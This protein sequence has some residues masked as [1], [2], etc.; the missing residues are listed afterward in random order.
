MLTPFLTDESGW[1]TKFKARWKRANVG[2]AQL[3]LVEPQTMMN[4]SGES[5]QS[6]AS[7]FRIAAEEILIVH[8]E[9]ELPFG[10][11]LVRRGG[12]LAGHNGLKSIAARLGTRE[13]LRLRIGIGRPQHGALHG[14]VLGRFTQEEEAELDWVFRQATKLVTDG[15]ARG[16]PV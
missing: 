11:V 13:F 2:S 9:V 10:E 8:D 14:H 15:L 16:F 5:V 3:V 1:Q 4:L 6:A 7:F 12:G